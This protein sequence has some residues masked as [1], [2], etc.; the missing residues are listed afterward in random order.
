[1]PAESLTGFRPERVLFEQKPRIGS[2]AGSHGA[3]NLSRCFR[4]DINYMPAKDNPASGALA[5][6]LERLSEF[7]PKLVRQSI[8]LH[9]RTSSA[10]SIPL[11]E[12]K[13]IVSQQES[14]CIKSHYF[15]MLHPVGQASF[16]NHIRCGVI[17]LEFCSLK[18]LPSNGNL[19]SSST[20][21]RPG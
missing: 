19:C 17:W 8:M 1:M 20:T 10:L 18:F 3:W 16:R 9:F 13:R 15:G 4:I 14:P 21:L 6:K 5:F 11:H 7:V 2:G 12:H